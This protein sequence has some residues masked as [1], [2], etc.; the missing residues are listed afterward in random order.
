[1][2]DNPS[3]RYRKNGDMVKSSAYDRLILEEEIATMERGETREHPMVYAGKNDKMP[4]RLVIYCLTVAE[5]RQRVSRIQRRAQQKYGKTKQ[6]NNDMAG[7]CVFMTI[8]PMSGPAEEV[9][10]LDRYRWQI[11]L[12]LRTWKTDLQVDIPREMKKERWECHL[13][14]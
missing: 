2:T 3:P 12:F 14:A 5:Q 6:Q 9:E 13:Y 4:V 7:I 10:F 11:E 1:Y 8:L